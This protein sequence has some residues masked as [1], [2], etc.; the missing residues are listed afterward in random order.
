MWPTGWRVHGAVNPAY[1]RGPAA[2]L[3]VETARYWMARI[4]RRADGTPDLLGRVMGPDEYSPFSSNNSYTDRLV[5]HALTLAAEVG[6]T[7]GATQEECA[8]F[9]QTAARLPMPRSRD[10]RLGAA[11]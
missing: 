2:P 9:A 8:A 3:L 10:G 5:C 1:L 4:D 11:M 6:E 7:V